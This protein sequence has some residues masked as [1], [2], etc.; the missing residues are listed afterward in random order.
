M[1]SLLL[2]IIIWVVGG[3]LACIILAYA[4]LLVMMAF[5]YV[6]GLVTPDKSNKTQIAEHPTH[7]PRSPEELARP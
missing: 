1:T 7:L 4:G 2:T 5:G 3:I 6:I